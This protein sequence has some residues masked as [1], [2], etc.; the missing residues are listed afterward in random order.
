MQLAWAE[1][2]VVLANVLRHY[3]LY[4]VDPTQSLEVAA[5]ITLQLV[6]GRYMIGIKKRQSV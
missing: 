4:E 6:S 3:H 5:Y 2:R 1:L